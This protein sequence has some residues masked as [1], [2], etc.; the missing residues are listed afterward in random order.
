MNLYAIIPSHAPRCEVELILAQDDAEAMEHGVFLAAKDLSEGVYFSTTAA[1]YRVATDLVKIG[2]AKAED[3]PWEWARY[4]PA[5]VAM[6][7]AE[8]A[9]LT[10]PST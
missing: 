5:L 9:V 4:V 6:Q 7:E 3:A 2:D 1:V 10:D 8:E